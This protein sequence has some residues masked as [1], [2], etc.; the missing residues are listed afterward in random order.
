MNLEISY[1][2]TTIDLEIILNDVEYSAPAGSTSLVI[3]YYPVL[4]QPNTLQIRCYNPEIIKYPVQI[5][6][7]MFDN[8]WCLEGNRTMIAR[9]L[10]SV[11]YIDYAKENNLF[12]DHNVNDNNNLFFMGDLIYSFYHPIQE[13]IHEI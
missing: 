8:F 4:R 9:N 5:T 7:I 1:S 3:E 10:Y 11:K 2:K 13:F 6:K 12:I